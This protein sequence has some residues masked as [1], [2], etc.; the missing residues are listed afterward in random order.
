MGNYAGGIHVV[1]ASKDGR[2]I[3]LAAATKRENAVPMTE[4]LLGSGWKATLTDKHLT[5]AQVEKLKLRPNGVR[6]LNYI[7]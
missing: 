3:Y 2:T 4:L 7:P 5:P 6:E 1:A